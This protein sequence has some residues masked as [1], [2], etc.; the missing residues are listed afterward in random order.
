MSKDGVSVSLS[1]TVEHHQ[2]SLTKSVSWIKDI[3]T[4]S[5]F[6]ETYTNVDMNMETNTFPYN[7]L[8]SAAF[9]RAASEAVSLSLDSHHEEGNEREFNP[10][11]L[12]IQRVVVTEIKIDGKTSTKTESSF[13]DS[14][15]TS[16]P[17]TYEERIERSRNHLKYLFAGDD[18]KIKGKTYAVHSCISKGMYILLA[19]YYTYQSYKCFY[20]Y[21]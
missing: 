7:P 2:R 19:S 20:S 18:G 15:P 11:F 12:Q 9:S 13:V 1:V 14:V 4:S 8:A 17:L 16:S 6:K 10:D 3:K 21:L 5:S